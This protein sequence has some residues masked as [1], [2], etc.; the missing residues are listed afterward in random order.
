MKDTNIHDRSMISNLAD[1]DGKTTG[2]I[3]NIGGVLV[4]RQMKDKLSE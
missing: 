4:N 2:H 1:P 3:S